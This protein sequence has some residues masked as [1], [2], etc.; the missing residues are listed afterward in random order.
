V[1]VHHGWDRERFLAALCR[2]AGVPDGA[3]AWP[4]AGLSGFETEAWSED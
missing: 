4:D 3:W 2:K 1:P